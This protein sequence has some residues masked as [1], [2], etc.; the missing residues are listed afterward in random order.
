[1][2]KVVIVGAGAVGATFAYA[3]EIHGA[4]RDSAYH[5]IDTKGA[6]NFAVGLAL[7]KI[8]TSILRDENS[9]LTVSTLV[10]GQY[11]ISGVCLSIPTVLDCGGVDWIMCPGLTEAEQA[12][13][14]RSAD[15]IREVQHQ[16][17]LP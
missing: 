6:T 4:V 14:K 16:V 5:I 15:A 13:L 12:D 9:V 1:M 2:G 11:G 10:D 8:T 3:L 7:V 17:G